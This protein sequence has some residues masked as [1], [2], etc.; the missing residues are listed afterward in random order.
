MT[1][2]VSTQAS[3]PVTPFELHLHFEGAFIFSIKTEN[4]SSD[5]NAKVTA[6][7]VYAPKCGHSNA[8]TINS[9]STY[10]L[11]SYWHCIDP[12]YPKAYTPTPITL[13]EVKT[14]I[15]AHTPM[16]SANRPIMGGWDIAFTLPVPPEDWACDQLVANAKASFSGQDA[17]TIPDSVALEQVLIY[18]NVTGANFHGFCFPAAFLP[19][20]GVAS[21]YLTS[22]VPYIPTLRHERQAADAMASLVGQDWVLQTPLGA[23][24]EVSGR[25]HVRQKTGNC[26]MGVVA[27]P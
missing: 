1:E 22:E 7:E 27:T 18:K 19:V 13:G 3:A 6:V 26:L 8:A 20:D 5:P 4:N 24:T 12:V 2:P 14:N 9:G 17:D 16:V 23:A 10:M 15:S 11:E 25:F 21:L